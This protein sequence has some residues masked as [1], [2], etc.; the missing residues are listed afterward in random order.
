M[1]QTYPTMHH[2]VTEMCTRAHFCYKILH[3]GI[4]H[5]CIL[6][7]VRWVY[8][9]RRE[10]WPHRLYD[11]HKV[12]HQV[13]FSI[14]ASDHSRQGKVLTDEK[15]FNNL[16]KIFRM[17]RLRRM[18]KTAQFWSQAITPKD[19]IAVL[20]ISIVTGIFQ[21]KGTSILIRKLDD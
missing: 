13:P 6:G 1:H 18:C 17:G 10:L 5:R 21:W 12:K 9:F 20:E 4:W 8:C 19:R 3:C 14:S 2:F 7:F 15:I 16:H 11:Q